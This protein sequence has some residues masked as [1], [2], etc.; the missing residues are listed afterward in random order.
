M[1]NMLSPLATPAATRDVL[2]EHGLSTKH[3]LGQNFLVNDAILQKIVELAQLDASDD[4]LEVGPGIGTLTIALLKCAGRVVSV[5]RDADL[6]A[7]LEDTLEPWADSFALISKDAL[8]LTEK[9][10]IEALAGYARL[11]EHGGYTPCSDSP[12]YAAELRAEHAP[13]ARVGLETH[14]ADGSPRTFPNKFV[15]NLP[16]AVAATLVLDFFQKFSQ[17]E[18]A[19]VMVQKEVADRMCAEPGSKNYGAYTVKLRLYA[20]PAG[21]FLV[22]P[23]NFFPPPHVDSSVLRL[24]R[25]PVFDAD[26]E[27]LDDAL[28][29]ATCA[30][31]DAAFA[32]RRKTISNSFKTYFASRGNA[33]KAFI[34]C[35][36][37]LLDEC[38]IDAKRRGETF[39]LDEF[40]ALGKAY[41]RRESNPL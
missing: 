30:M 12:R 29:K 39:S 22:S 23:N 4:V 19:T 41:L 20:E 9:D 27:P 15:A 25:R 37:D 18:S 35:I 7:V 36:P 31:A 1:A 8:E 21:R 33:G 13:H 40:I 11:A 10:V 16:Y 2:E 24:D 6:P 32:S 14:G 26:G 34:G 28:L 17:L 3:A 38:G 5:E